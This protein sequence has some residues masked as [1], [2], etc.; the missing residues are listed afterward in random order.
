MEEIHP[1][2]RPRVSSM[3]GSLTREK[4]VLMPQPLTT[5]MPPVDVYSTFV[6]TLVNIKLIEKLKNL[7][8]TSKILLGLGKKFFNYKIAWLLKTKCVF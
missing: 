7:H 5:K 1:S 3:G 4:P 6:Y 2:K 8:K